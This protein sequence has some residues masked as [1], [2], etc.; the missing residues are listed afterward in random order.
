MNAYWGKDYAKAI[1]EFEAILRAH[2]G[3]SYAMAYRTMA[4]KAKAGD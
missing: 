1:H 2:P 4:E 3:D